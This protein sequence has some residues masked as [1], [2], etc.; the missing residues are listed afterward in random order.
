MFE[1]AVGGCSQLPVTALEFATDTILLA[2]NGGSLSVY[3]C[4]SRLRIGHELV[5]PYGPRIYGIHV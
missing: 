3:N 5:F 2:A 4:V 1:S